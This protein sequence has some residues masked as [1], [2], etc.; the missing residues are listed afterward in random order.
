MIRF[1]ELE[2]VGP[3]RQV[4]YIGER[5]T[6]PVMGPPIQ[7]MDVTDY[8]VS[9]GQ[10][11]DPDADTFVDD[12]PVT[13]K[14]KPKVWASTLAFLREF[15]QSERVIIRKAAAQD[16]VVDD[17]LFMLQQAQE[18]EANDADVVAGMQYLVD[19]DHITSTRRDEILNQV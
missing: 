11:Y 10:Y 19:Q 15:S 5:E 9:V 17:F 2:R 12:P 18:V 4:R 3:N 8:T 6:L 13:P 16:D 7:V 14:P 1:A